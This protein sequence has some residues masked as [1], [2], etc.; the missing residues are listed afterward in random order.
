MPARLRILLVSIDELKRGRRLNISSRPIW[1]R[2]PTSG[3][4]REL[5]EAI[6]TV[7]NHGIGFCEGVGVTENAGVSVDFQ[8]VSDDR[9]RATMEFNTQV[10]LECSKETFVEKGSE[11][12]TEMLISKSK[13]PLLQLLDVKPETLRKMFLG[14]MSR[15]EDVL[16]QGLLLAQALD[17]PALVDRT[18]ASLPELNQSESEA[19]QESCDAKGADGRSASDPESV[20]CRSAALPAVAAAVAAES[21]LEQAADGRS[22]SAAE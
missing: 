3:S 11:Y 21:E 17:D 8:E 14:E 9:V 1:A 6:T 7:F 16:R 13:A 12:V 18:V 10:S 20:A 4:K 19:L 22:A 5:F 2:P 15:V